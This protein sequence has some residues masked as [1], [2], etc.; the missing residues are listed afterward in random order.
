MP[1]QLD[2]LKPIVIDGHEAQEVIRQLQTQ[3]QVLESRLLEVLPVASVATVP[4]IDLSSIG[5]PGTRQ[6]Q[7]WRYTPR[8]Q[9][10]SESGRTSGSCAQ[11]LSAS[12]GMRRLE[13]ELELETKRREAA[14]RE[15][16]RLRMLMDKSRL[17][18]KDSP[19]LA[20]TSAIL[21]LG[22]FK[23][24]TRC[25]NENEQHTSN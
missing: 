24:E 21:R 14:E 8:G 13:R 17:V 22:T 7:L 12:M 1:L 25:G 2:T 18:K 10:P 11:P 4:K 16:V 6:P 23:R 3:K 5:T 19:R 20:P 9:L 15:I